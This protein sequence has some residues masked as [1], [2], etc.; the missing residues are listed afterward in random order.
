MKEI[1][2]YS[3]KINKEPSLEIIITLIVTK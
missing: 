3:N 1:D 2:R